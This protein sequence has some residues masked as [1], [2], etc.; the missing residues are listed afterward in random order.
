MTYAQFLR[1]VPRNYVR[2]EGRDRRRDFAYFMLTYFCS[3]LAGAL[4]IVL[5][6]AV[7]QDWLAAIGVVI[8]FAAMLGGWLPSISYS[9]RRLHDINL[10]GWWYLAFLVPYAGL[11]FWAAIAFIDGTK[12]S[13]RFGESPKYASSHRYY[14]ATEPSLSNVLIA[15]MDWLGA[16]RENFM[17]ALSMVGA[18]SHWAQAIPAGSPMDA[19]LDRILNVA[20][21]AP[22]GEVV[23]PTLRHHLRGAVAKGYGIAVTE[24]QAGL[25]IPNKTHCVAL[26]AQAMHDF[27]NEMPLSDEPFPGHDASPRQLEDLALRRGYFEARTRTKQTL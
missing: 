6:E 3:L 26:C 9:V 13:N 7:R 10:S 18:A 15:D 20:I 21:P 19:E 24:E 4:L 2:F 25:A 23:D 11:V 14:D 8:F 27:G 1:S 5:G 12:G 17:S 16:S 22:Y